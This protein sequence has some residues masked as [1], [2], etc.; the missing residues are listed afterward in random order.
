MISQ[1]YQEWSLGAI[2][3]KI[4]FCAETFMRWPY[5]EDMKRKLL[6]ITKKIVEES[7]GKWI[8]FSYFSVFIGKKRV[9]PH[10]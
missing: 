5:N 6:T 1:I 2:I 10:L 8:I 7:G 9:W 4:C 3:F